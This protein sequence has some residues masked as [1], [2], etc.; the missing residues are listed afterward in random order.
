[1]LFKTELTS[2]S[3]MERMDKIVKALAAHGIDAYTKTLDN[4]SGGLL[5]N[6]RSSGTFGM[7]SN[8][9]FLYKIYVKREAYEQAKGIA[10]SIE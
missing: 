2:T 8:V 3:S 6:R 5:T 4:F 10:A 7:D 9:R 1:M